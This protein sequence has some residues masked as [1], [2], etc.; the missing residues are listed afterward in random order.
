MFV[1]TVFH[2]DVHTGVS[3]GLPT[4]PLLGTSTNLNC[5]VA[6]HPQINSSILNITY[7]WSSNGLIKYGQKLH[8]PNLSPAD[9]TTYSCNVAIS[10]AISVLLIKQISNQSSFD[11]VTKSELIKFVAIACS[12]SLHIYSSVPAPTVQ[13]SPSNRNA[14]YSG[15]DL[16]VT[17]ISEVNSVVFTWSTFN[18]SP[19]S[20]QSTIVNTSNHTSVIV[21]KS[22]NTNEHSLNFVSCNVSIPG[23]VNII[24][25]V[26]AR[27]I[28]VEGK[29]V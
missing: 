20:K 1:H 16:N 18:S 14:Y 5:S 23:N 9:A 22:L 29:A 24:S 6:L 13:L 2:I 28:N 27:M 15:E 26:N 8:L 17:C 21:Y 25:G 4:L 3:D 11:L 19:L 7:L 10:S 12:I